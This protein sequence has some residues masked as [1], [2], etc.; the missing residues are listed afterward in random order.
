MNMFSRGLL[1]S[2]H[3]F[4]AATDWEYV[5]GGSGPVRVEAVSKQDN[6]PRAM[7]GTTSMIS[8]H[9]FGDT[10]WLETA[11]VRG[12]SQ[13]IMYP[14]AVIRSRSLGVTMAL[15]DPPIKIQQWTLPI[16]REIAKC[17]AL[18]FATAKR[19]PDFTL[20]LQLN[21]MRIMMTRSGIKL[22]PCADG[23]NEEIADR[24][25]RALIDFA[26]ILPYCPK[27][28]RTERAL[29]RSCYQRGSTFAQ[30]VNEFVDLA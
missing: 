26:R 22:L 24:E 21:P 6:V 3:P 27:P 18:Y 20:R 28:G 9:P 30:L 2:V 17:M 11:E 19:H 13:Y 15:L 23:P 5:R 10:P 25:E 7:I 8:F 1:A 14:H 4:V 29:I 12:L 16:L